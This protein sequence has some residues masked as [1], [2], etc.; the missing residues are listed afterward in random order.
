VPVYPRLKALRAGIPG[1][2]KPL[3]YWLIVRQR[4]HDQAPLVFGWSDFHETLPI[5]GREDEA[6]DFLRHAG[7]GDAWRVGEVGATE[8]I[9]W[10][11]RTGAGVSRIALD[12]PVDRDIF[13]GMLK[14]VSVE[15]EVFV[16]SIIGSLVADPRY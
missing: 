14:L 4:R 7:F 15:R 2:P 8:I 16:R 10:L 9:S 13:R 6:L 1:S 5:F 11:H 12:P 3:S